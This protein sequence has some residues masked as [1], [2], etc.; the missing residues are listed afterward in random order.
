MKRFGIILL[1]LAISFAM[2][3]PAMAGGWTFYGQ[4][5]ASVTGVNNVC[6]PAV[7]GRTFVAEGMA[8]LPKDSA[9]TLAVYGGTGT[10]AIAAT[11]QSSGSVTISITNGTNVDKTVAGQVLYTVT[12]ISQDPMVETIVFLGTVASTASSATRGT[13][14]VTVAGGSGALAIS[15]RVRIASIISAADLLFGTEVDANPIIFSGSNYSSG[16][17]WAGLATQFYPIEVLT[18][19]RRGKDTCYVVAGNGSTTT[20]AIYYLTGAFVNVK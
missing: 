1:A 6:V 12:N 3:V 18:P 17:T 19:S 2:A 20:G 16:G 9:V 13:E 4:D 8:I 10:Y 11:S 5:A 7:K 14:L 15:A